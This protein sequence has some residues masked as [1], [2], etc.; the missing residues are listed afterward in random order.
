MAI[1]EKF[2]ATARTEY[3]VERR[4]ILTRWVE[5]I[6]FADQEAQ[7]TLRLPFAEA[8][9]FVTFAQAVSRTLDDCSS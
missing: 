8:G 4:T 5:E 3:P 2:R 9:R 1:T 6:S 7:V